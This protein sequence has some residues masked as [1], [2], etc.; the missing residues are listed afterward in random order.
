MSSHALKRLEPYRFVAVH[1][2]R[3]HLNPTITAALL[4]Q[5]LRRT[6]RSPREAP[7]NGSSR[8]ERRRRKRGY[9]GIAGRRRARG[10]VVP[11]SQLFPSAAAF[12][13]RGSTGTRPHKGD[14]HRGRVALLVLNVDERGALLDV[15]EEAERPA[16]RNTKRS[17]G[18]PRRAGAA[19][20]TRDGVLSRKVGLTRP[21]SLGAA[22]R[23]GLRRS[24]CDRRGG[25]SAGRVAP[26]C[27]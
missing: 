6:P 17:R 23:Q 5:T 16:R 9:A 24:V 8:C 7:P 3:S 18:R 21:T 25:R 27:E 1:V 15:L 26:R 14:Q 10:T 20:I 2:R 4:A 22:P 19:W 13:N 11:S 12:L